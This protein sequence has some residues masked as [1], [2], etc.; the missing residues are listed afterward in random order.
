MSFSEASKPAARSNS[1]E[2]RQQFEM[3][4]LE[5]KHF[6]DKEK[7]GHNTASLLLEGLK[8]RICSQTSNWK[9]GG[10]ES[11]QLPVSLRSAR[12]CLLPLPSAAFL[13][14]SSSW[15]SSSMAGHWESAPCKKADSG[16]ATQ[17]LSNRRGY[18]YR[19]SAEWH[20][21]LFIFLLVRSTTMEVWLC[22][23]G[24]QLLQE[25]KENPFSFPSFSWNHLLVQLIA[26]EKNSA[27]SWMTK[28]S[29]ARPPH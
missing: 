10:T 8:K 12:L 5:I 24:K 16:E 23:A 13:F 3:Q 2:A 26:G 27:Y 14:I 15:L 4:C 29:T 21:V 25:E 20:L 22:A 18:C 1:E 6:S 28:K 11:P 9:G 17:H 7:D 19:T